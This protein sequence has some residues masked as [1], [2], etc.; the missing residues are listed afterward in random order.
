MN[1]DDKGTVPATNNILLCC[2]TP[3]DTN[4]QSFR[5]FFSELPLGR[6]MTGK[7]C[8]PRTLTRRFLFFFLFSLDA[9]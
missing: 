6:L 8:L 9:F 4:A 2:A 5:L 1:D 3:D 7:A